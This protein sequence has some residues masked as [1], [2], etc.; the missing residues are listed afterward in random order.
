MPPTNP[1][2]SPVTATSKNGGLNDMMA[3]TLSV[4][5]PSVRTSIVLATANHSNPTPK[6]PLK[7]ALKPLVGK[8]RFTPKAQKATTHQ[9]KNNCVK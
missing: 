4:S 6:K 9:G 2:I 3:A 7:K 5:S 1:P 8:K